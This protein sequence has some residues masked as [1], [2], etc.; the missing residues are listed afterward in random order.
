M[1][2]VC[3]TQGPHVRDKIKAL[4]PSKVSWLLAALPGF[5]A[6]A[7]VG[8]NLRQSRRSGKKLPKAVS[9]PG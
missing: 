5:G 4:E 2:P 7:N 3:L 9:L 6:L 1:E 8:A